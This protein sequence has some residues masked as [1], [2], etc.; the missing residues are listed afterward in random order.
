MHANG[1]DLP[2]D[3]DLPRRAGAI[4][5]VSCYELGHQPLNLASPLA[6]LRRAGYAPAAVD[7]S[8]AALSDE[9]RSA[10]ARLVAISVPMHTA[11]RLGV[12][13]AERVRRSTRRRTS[14]STA[15]TPRSTPTICCASYADSVIGGEYEEALLALVAGA[16]AGRLGL[17]DVPACHDTRRDAPLQCC[18]PR[19]VPTR[20]RRAARAAT[21]RAICARGRGGAWR[22]TSRRAAAACIPAA[23][24][25]SRRSTAGASSSCRARRR[26]GRHPRAGARRGAPHHLRRPRLPQRARPLAG[27]SRGRCTP[28]SPS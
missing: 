25:R 20:A 14:A 22:G 11:L 18:A 27:I 23:T 7:T 8:V 13:V 21:L 28:S 5:L 12:R 16:G 9:T 4:L 19:A 2:T 15:S 1:A 24:A 10:R 6:L 3:G 26:A 17:P